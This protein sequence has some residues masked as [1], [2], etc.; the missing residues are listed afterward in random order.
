MCKRTIIVVYRLLDIDSWWD[1]QQFECVC[2][3]NLLDRCSKP[4]TM[5][6][7][8]RG[9]VAPGGVL[10]LALVLPYKPYVEGNIMS[11]SCIISVQTLWVN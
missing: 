9:A 4:K 6:K 10:M 8:A 7:Q 3:L 5:L 11:Y 1:G 2:M